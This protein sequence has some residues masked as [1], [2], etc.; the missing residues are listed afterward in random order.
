[1]RSGGW[2]LALRVARREALRAPR[3][4]VLVLVMIALP[5]RRWRWPTPS[6]TPGSSR[7]EGL[8]RRLGAAAVLVE[9]GSSSP[10]L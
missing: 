3:R 8:E 6:T 5:V 9:V 4:S 2:R 1:M 10:E 7:C